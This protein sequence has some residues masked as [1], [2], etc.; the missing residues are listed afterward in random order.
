VSLI[1]R[2]AEAISDA[3]RSGS[4]A[5]PFDQRSQSG[6]TL[7]ELIVV[8]LIIILVLGISYPS[9]E[10][11]STILNLQTASRDIL[12]TFRFA[13]EKAISEQTSMLLVINRSERRFEL[14]N[15]FGEPM[16]SYTLP[17]GINIQSVTR[18]GSE[19]Q[20]NICAVRFAPNGNLENIGIR[21]VSEN[22]SRRMQI[23]SDPLG[24]GARIEPVWEDLR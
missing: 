11:G 12:N 21:I 9:M 23:I 14:A 18:A 7:L 8:T 10:R 3:Q 13:R 6:F 2:Y 20:D 19:V 4:P 1:Q 5:Q 16:R 24:G 15:I 22:G 17:R